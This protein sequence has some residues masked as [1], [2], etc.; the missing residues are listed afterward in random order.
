VGV[1]TPLMKMGEV[2]A[3]WAWMLRPVPGL[4]GRTNVVPTTYVVG[5]YLSP[6][7]LVDQGGL[8]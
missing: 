6:Y 2:L 7:G 4:D 3:W 5:Y 1:L 8:G